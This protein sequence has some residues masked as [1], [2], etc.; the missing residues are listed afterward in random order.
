MLTALEETMNLHPKMMRDVKFYFGSIDTR[1]HVYPQKQPREVVAHDWSGP[2]ALSEKGEWFKSP[3]SYN[4]HRE[5]TAEEAAANIHLH[6]F[7]K[8]VRS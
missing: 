2:W 8:E 1:W 4:L 6:A 3:V 5:I 7:Q